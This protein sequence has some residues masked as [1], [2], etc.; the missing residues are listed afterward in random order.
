MI[1]QNKGVL[2]EKAL[3]KSLDNKTL[4]ELNENLKKFVKFLFPN[5]KDNDR[6]KCEK[7]GENAKGDIQVIVK[8][9]TK[10]VS[11]K[12][13]KGL[14][15]HEE[16]FYTFKR[17]FLDIHNCPL[18]VEKT[19]ERF[20]V[21]L[22][23]DYK[24]KITLKEENDVQ[25]FLLKNRQEL[26]ERFIKNGRKKTSAEYIYYG[27]CNEGEWMEIDE[28]ITKFSSSKCKGFFKIGGIS[29]QAYCRKCKTKSKEQS[30]RLQA[31]IGSDTLKKLSKKVISYEECN[32]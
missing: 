8:K 20:I 19:L 6:I 2:N 18:E 25:E 26:L 7:Q 24:K 23:L 16:N 28:V 21:K 30:E 22:G 3:I 9:I 5:C 4:S 29:L 10:R 14:S 12:I 31:K 27:N 11:V 1:G 32:D 13:G 15:I 17:E